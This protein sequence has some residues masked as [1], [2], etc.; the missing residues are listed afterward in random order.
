MIPDFY[1]PSPA[2][3]T[4]IENIVELVG[5]V[6]A[7]EELSGRVPEL[8]RTNRLRAVH[9]STAIEGNTM[10]L[11]QVAAIAEGKPVIA[12][13]REVQENANALAAYETLGELDPWSVDDL[14]RTH[15]LLTGG[16][17]A[18]S[19]A[20]RTV[21]VEIVNSDG[22]VLHTG[23]RFSKVPR[24]VTELLEW[25]RDSQDHPL[26]VS[27]AV[28][29]LIEQIHPFRDGNGRLGRLWQTLILSKWRELFQWMPTETL[30]RQNQ[31][32]YYRA[33]QDSRV[34]EID[35]G[36][37]IDYMLG[38]IT[39]TLVSSEAQA[40]ADSASVGVNVGVNVGVRGEIVRLLREDPTLSAE[41]LGGILGKSTRTI[42]RHRRELRNAGM[43][44]REGSDRAGRWMIID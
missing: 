3:P 12:A 30:V 7:A 21:D 39:D 43:L 26:V 5:R 35:A 10:T 34:P 6:R 36:P 20:F 32:D 11:A 8:R 29:F 33:L 37:F 17:V 16:L 40:F 22:L 23:S 41:A 14:L 28:H 19:G 13:P 27:S 9:S 24:L 1:T 25:A 2:W 18:E 42:E 4:R 44:R 31:E 38:T 15:G